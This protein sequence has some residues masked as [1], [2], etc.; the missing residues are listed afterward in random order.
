VNLPEPF[1]RPYYKPKK[2]KPKPPPRRGGAMGD[3]LSDWE[4]PKSDIA[5]F[6]D[7]Y[8]DLDGKETPQAAK[9]TA[10]VLAAAGEK[11]LTVKG[12]LG[13]TVLTFLELGSCPWEHEMCPC[14]RLIEEGYCKKKM[15]VPSL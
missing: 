14:S 10:A 9:I 11:G 12:D 6:W 7:I 8:H 5:T 1:Y 3:L 2:A 15:L 4:P 13:K